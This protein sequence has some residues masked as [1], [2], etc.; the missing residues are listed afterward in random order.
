MKKCKHC[1]EE[2]PYSEYYKRKEMKDGYLKIC[3]NCLRIKDYQTRRDHAL[4]Y[5]RKNKEYIASEM[6]RRYEESKDGLHHVYVSEKYN[7]AG[8]TCHPPTR[9]RNHAQNGRPDIDM[10]IIYSTPNRKEGLELEELLH[11]LGYEGRHASNRYV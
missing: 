9:K 11:D 8:I 1:N 3:K 10:R 4:K 6:K 2:K 5:N 7:Y